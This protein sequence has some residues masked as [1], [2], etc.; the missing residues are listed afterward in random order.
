MEEKEPKAEEE[1]AAYKAA[2][3]EFDRA[4]SRNVI[5]RANASRHISR[6]TKHYKAFQANAG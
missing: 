1:E 3:R 6:L 4:W 5:K 2:I